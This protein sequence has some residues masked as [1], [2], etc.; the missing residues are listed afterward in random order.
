MKEENYEK[1]LKA[2]SEVKNFDELPEELKKDIYDIEK[3]LDEE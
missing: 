1:W 3:E 2:K